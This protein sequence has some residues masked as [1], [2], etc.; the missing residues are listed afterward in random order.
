MCFVWLSEQ[1]VTFISHILNRLVFY[2][3]SGECLRALSPYTVRSESR[4]AL[5]TVL[6]VIEITVVSKT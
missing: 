5:I 1:T 6:E 3:R 4:C 2:N